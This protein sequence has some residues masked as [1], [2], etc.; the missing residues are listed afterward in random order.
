MSPDGSSVYVASYSGNVINQFAVTANGGLGASTSISAGGSQ[1]LGMALTPDG[2]SFYAVLSNTGGTQMYDVA[3]N[4]SLTAKS[5]TAFRGSGGTSGPYD[6]A[7]SP[8]GNSAYVVLTGTDR[9]AQYDVA[10]GGVL[11]AKSPTPTV[12]TG[13][14]PLS[15]VT[16]PNQPP[17]AALSATPAGPG[18]ATQ[19]DASAT[20]DA[21][22]SVARYDWDFGDGSTLSDGGATPNHTYA[23]AGTYTATVTATDN[24]GCSDTLVWAGRTASC[25]GSPVAR[26][27]V[28]VQIGGGSTP[29]TPTP[30]TPS[31]FGLHVEPGFFRVD[32]N[33]TVLASKAAPSGSELQFKLNADAKVEFTLEKRVPGRMVSGRCVAPKAGN[34]PRRRCGRSYKTVGAAGSVGGFSVNGKAGVNKLPFSARLSSGDLGWGVYRLKGVATKSGLSSPPRYSFFKIAHP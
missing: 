3:G 29:S 18:S 30:A 17:V 7:V 19:F 8:D 34:A 16:T 24:E 27:S 32:S 20:T 11:N 33:G 15:V 26:K 12:A 6:I 28:Q 4:G 31:L 23:N 21:D 22:G 13:S 1:P 9:V 25:N 10:S 2:T 5:P 14:T